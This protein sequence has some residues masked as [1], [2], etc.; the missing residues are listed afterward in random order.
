MKQIRPSCETINICRKQLLLIV[1]SF[2][3]GGIASCK[4]LKKSSSN[5]T[6]V[7]GK[8]VSKPDE[9]PGTYAVRSETRMPDGS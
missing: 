2:A 6:V 8:P 5:L 1:I 9:G 3:I 7:N 4:G